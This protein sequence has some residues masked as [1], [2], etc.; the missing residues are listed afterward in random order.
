MKSPSGKRG[1][2]W[3]FASSA[4]LAFAAAACSGVQAV[5]RSGVQGTGRK[6]GILGVLLAAVCVSLFRS[7]SCVFARIVN[8]GKER[9]AVFLPW[10]LLSVSR[11]RFVASDL[12][13]RNSGQQR[14]GRTIR[15][16]Y[17]AKFAKIT[18]F[19]LCLIC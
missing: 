16:R 4:L 8:T 6:A 7:L 1:E 14:N 13:S 17:R 19:A 9:K 2:T 18:R 15:S 11:S 3:V 12:R 5:G 10:L